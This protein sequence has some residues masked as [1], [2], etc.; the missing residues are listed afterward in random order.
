[1]GRDRK[2]G[3]CSNIRT[4]DGDTRQTIVKSK[5]EID[6]LAP[7]PL[8]LKGR[9]TT[10]KTTTNYATNKTT[11]VTDLRPQMNTQTNTFDKDKEGKTTR[12]RQKARYETKQE[13]TT[14]GTLSR[15][16]T[17][18]TPTDPSS[19]LPRTPSP[20][21]DPDTIANHPPYSFKPL[22]LNHHHNLHHP[23]LPPPPPDPR[24]RISLTKGLSDTTDSSS[25]FFPSQYTTGPRS[26]GPPPP[27]GAGRL[28]PR[29]WG[30]WL[31]R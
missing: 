27:Q 8:P 30:R 9:T 7:P 29:G 13:N 14:P 19:P 23:P 12:R 21:S 4:T 1:M 2:V 20:D 5:T 26:L 22:P 6:F 18:A 24:P 11:N 25:N 10:N 15:C 16:K 28:N 17:H 31:G 3:R